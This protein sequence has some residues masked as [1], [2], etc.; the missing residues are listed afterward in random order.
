MP[1]NA[2]Y[3]VVGKL[4]HHGLR[5]Q[6]SSSN[7][8]LG[9]KKVAL[10]MTDQSA[11]STASATLELDRSHQP[12]RIPAIGGGDIASVVA[13]AGQI[14]DR[15]NH[16]PIED[17]SRNIQ[18]ITARIKQ[19]AASPE[20]NQSLEHLNQALANV[21]QIT[22]E[23]KG[24][25]EPTLRSLRKAADAAESTAKTL[26][27]ITGGS[28]HNQQNIESLVQEL[29]RTARSIRLFADYLNRHPEALIQGRSER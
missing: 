28:L 10:V 3:E 5:T 23:A 12:P 13:S 4:V 27:R 24:E 18:E 16:V 21:E 9:S 15:I 14:A 25:I 26:N 1:A 22:S 2:L 11:A 19:I 20:I 17:I 6:L 7:L 29:V 8:L